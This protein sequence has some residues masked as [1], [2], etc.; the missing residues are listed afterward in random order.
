MKMRFAIRYAP[1][2]PA[3]VKVPGT[4][5]SLMADGPMGV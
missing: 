5:Q 2:C 4:R 1:Y 3:D